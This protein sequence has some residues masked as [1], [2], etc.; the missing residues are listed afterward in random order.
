MKT[1][2]CRPFFPLILFCLLANAG[3]AVVPIFPGG[4][5]GAPTNTPLNSW[6]FYNSTNWA[7]DSGRLPI[8]FTNIQHSYLGNGSSLVVDTNVPAW[9]EYPVYTSGVTNFIP[10]IG[11][12]TF[13]FAANWNSTNAGGTGP[14][15]YGRLFEVGGYTADNSYGWW[16]LLLDGGNHIYFS[17]QTND[18]SG[19]L[20][21]YLATPVS[22]TTNYFHFIALTY[23]AT[24]TALYLD[25]EL[26]TNG[27]PVTI[28]PGADVLAN[29]FFI[30]SDNTGLLQAHG[31]FN[32]LKTYNYSLDSNTVSELFDWNFGYYMMSPWNA[33][34][35]N[36]II[37]APSSPAPSGSTYNAITGQGSLQL[38]GA[39]ADC[40][41]STNVWLTN[42]VATVAGNGTMSVTFTIAGGS[43][44]AAYD[45][46]ANSVLD[47]SSNPNLAWAWM[48]QGAHCN[49]Y[50]LTNLPNT[51]CYLILGTAQDSDA[52]GL[53][54]AYEKLVSKTDPN[55]PD[56]DG[57]GI[58][59]SWE[60]LLG[61][62]PLTNDNAQS[63]S[64]FNY[65]Y[66]LADW[67]S[68]VSGVKSGT[69][70]ADNEGNMLQVSQ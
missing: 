17:A 38:V 21:T 31:M 63:G 60:V 28:Y 24:N 12:V 14:G 3:H 8:G 64:R 33:P 41:T 47:F 48:G 1:Q 40:V 53:T 62:N 69:V 4:G 61:M 10:A 49:I 65:A 68:G 19:T 51:A 25:G 5:G 32:S 56:T 35:M 43:S 36:S 42:I 23:S 37:S 27:P 57:D 6:S 16:S 13:W 66:T 52:D 46:F 39:A 2:L 44:G 22:F 30:G 20:T 45:V 26:L 11:S 55:N 54:D 59:D 34:Y 18:A 70:S 15:D 58:S 50:T 7:D 67:L 9:L 29:G